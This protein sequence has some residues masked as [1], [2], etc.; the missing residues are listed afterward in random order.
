MTMRL[1]CRPSPRCW[2]RTGPSS[3]LHRALVTDS[4]GSRPVRSSTWCVTMPDIGGPEGVRRVRARWPQLKVGII[5]GALPNVN[6]DVFSKAQR[7]ARVLQIGL[8]KG[9][10]VPR[11]SRASPAPPRTAPPMMT[12]APQG[13]RG[14]HG[15]PGVPP[16]DSR[17]CPADH[18]I[19][20]NFTTYSGE[21]CI[22]HVPGGVFYGK[23]KPE[24]CHVS[25]DEARQDGCRTSTR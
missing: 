15:R 11:G 4:R 22:D 1:C 6:Q 19:K 8:W 23:T 18:P 7:E 17:T 3:S 12:D 25:G 20:A 16:Q 2:R 5:T 10:G 21:R 13:A 14:A 9:T 24:R